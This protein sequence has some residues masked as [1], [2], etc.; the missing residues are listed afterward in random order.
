MMDPGEAA[1]VTSAAFLAGGVNAIAGGG[2]LISFPAL[3]AVGVKPV[4]ANITNTVALCSG[5]LGGAISQR[6]ALTGQRDRLRRLLVVG[7]LGGLTGAV[8]L[9]STSDS[10]FKRL[11][12]LLIL[13]AS[14]LLGFQDRIR[15]WFG[16]GEQ[17]V[18]TGGA[19]SADPLWLLLPVFAVAVYGGYFGA[20]LGIMML[21]VLGVV[22]HE[23]LTRLNAI[24][25]MLSLVI[26]VVAAAFFMFSGKVHWDF[27]AVM[28]I[29]S[30]AGGAVGG[31]VANRLDPKV[32]RLVVI[33]IALVVA[34]VYFVRSL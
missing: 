8:L 9:V 12:P 25:Q 3:L 15:Q 13:L 1:L 6:R 26:N 20:G 24:K 18:V 23:S 32:L 30:L 4:A 5:Y 33:V 16:I 28:A 34:V 11:I 29:G 31:R 22:L 2:S 10:V 21:G 7:G 27:A 19:T 14:G 17:V